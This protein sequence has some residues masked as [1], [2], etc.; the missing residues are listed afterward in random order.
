MLSTG[1]SE[2]VE[3]AFSRAQQ[4]TDKEDNYD[5]GQ[6]IYVGNLPFDF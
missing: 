4:V 6:E 5:S 2:Y 1:F 3:N